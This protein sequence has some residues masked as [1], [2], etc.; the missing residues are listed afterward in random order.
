MRWW[1]SEFPPQ[2]QKRPAWKEGIEY[3]ACASR[4]PRSG[5]H[6]TSAGG[7][8]GSMEK[9]MTD[10]FAKRSLAGRRLDS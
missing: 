8:G 4:H 5:P 7:K 9:S 10:K 3:A 1:F 2:D 6:L